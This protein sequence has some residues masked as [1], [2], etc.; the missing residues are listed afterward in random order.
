MPK[1]P[2]L[3]RHAF[4]LIF[5]ICLVAL[6]NRTFF[7]DALLLSKANGYYTMLLMPVFYVFALVFIFEV[8]SFYGAL[9]YKITAGVMVL[10]AGISRYFIDDLGIG[11]T[12]DAIESLFNTTRAEAAAFLGLEFFVSFFVFCAAP[13]V[14]II[15]LKFPQIPLAKRLWQKLAALVLS[16]AISVLLWGAIGKDLIFLIENSKRLENIANPV[17]VIRRL[18]IYLDNKRLERDFTQV[19][20]DAKKVKILALESGGGGASTG[21]GESTG[22]NGNSNGGTSTDANTSANPNA[23]NFVFVLIIGES[24]RGQNFSLN[25]YAKETNPFTK[26][27]QDLTSFRHFAS[28]GVIT[29]VS[30]PCML[31]HKPRKDY[32]END[33]E[34]MENVLD[35]AQRVGIDV[36]WFGN[37]GSCAAGVCNRLRHVKYYDGESPDGIMLHDVQAAVEN[38]TR[39]SLIVINQRGSHGPLYAKRYPSEFEVFKPAC[40]NKAVQKCSYEEVQNAYDNSLVYSDWFLSE[41]VKILQAKQAPTALW[42]VSDHGESLGEDGRFMHGGLPYYFA[43][44]YETTVGSIIWFSKAYGEFLPK[45]RAAQDLNLSQDFVFSS[46]LTLLGIQTSLYNK[47][48]D[49]FK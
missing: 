42:F 47:D 23:Q 37:N 15:G 6:Y 11:I 31:T 43:P 21:A 29:R 2:S 4:L 26:N 35:I 45:A 1:R 13:L 22:A 36:F 38:A 20:L 19:G 27:I 12:N 28:C 9:S 3:N 39:A 14:I 34:Y 17:S 10:I 24:A 44:K 30:I 32:G 46:L 16:L 33:G 7:G 49:I 25:G 41:V 18:A 8:L 5:A 48:L 40:Q